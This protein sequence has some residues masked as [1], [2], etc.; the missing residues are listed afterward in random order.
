MKLLP[1]VPAM[2][3]AL[4]LGGCI[5]PTAD[6][7]NA[8]DSAEEDLTSAF[9]YTCHADYGSNKTKILDLTV[10]KTTAKA[11][12]ADPGEL[13]LP[14]K[15]SYVPDYKPNKPAYQNKAKYKFD[16]GSGHVTVVL[17]DKAMRTGGE[18]LSGGAHGG[19]VIIE[20][21]GV[22]KGLVPLFCYR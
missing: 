1:L 17:V 7:E 8:A 19:K 18:K 21:P 6:D 10:G 22:S 3:A 9:K 5:A 16:D 11:V 2:L 15:Y 20:G 14:L 12:A 4:L 13:S